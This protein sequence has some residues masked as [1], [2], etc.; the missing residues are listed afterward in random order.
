MLQ[1]LLLVYWAVALVMAVLGLRQHWVVL[2]AAAMLLAHIAEIPL[3]LR[4]LAHKKPSTGTVAL[5]TLVV[6]LLWWVPARRDLFP[7]R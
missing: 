6:G 4:L 5:N 2:V 7:V 3:A 1:L